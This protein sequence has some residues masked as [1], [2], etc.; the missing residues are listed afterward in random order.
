M[1]RFHAY[2]TELHPTPIQDTLMR[3][4]CGSARFDYNRFLAFN[5]ERLRNCEPF[6]NH[7]MFA[8]DKTKVWRVSTAGKVQGG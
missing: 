7:M 2:R 8:K 4:F 6:M 5:Q 1:R 3:K